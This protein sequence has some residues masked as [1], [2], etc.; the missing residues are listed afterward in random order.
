[1]VKF[2]EVDASNYI[3][4]LL[5][6]PPPPTSKSHWFSNVSGLFIIVPQFNSF[7]KKIIYFSL[8]RNNYNQWMVKWMTQWMPT[9]PMNDS[10]TKLF[11]LFRHLLLGWLKNHFCHN[12]F[13]SKK[14]PFSFPRCVFFLFLYSF[15]F[16]V[17]SS[18]YIFFFSFSFN[19]YS[20]KNCLF[21]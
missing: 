16:S 14:L 4:L 1:M 10:R 9:Q 7:C 13:S 18:Y 21:Q 5:A 3:T 17:A 19:F 11:N 2:C 12:Q 8:N 20:N 6:L 15:S